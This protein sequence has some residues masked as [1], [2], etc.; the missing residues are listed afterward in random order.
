MQ[1]FVKTIINAVQSWTKKEIK[2]SVADWN[3][4]DASAVDYVK[5]RTHWVDDVEEVIFERQLIDFAGTIQVIFMDYM[6]NEINSW[7]NVK[8][9]VFWDGVTYDCT[10]IGNGTV[11]QINPDFLDPNLPFYIT[12]EPYQT[13]IRKKSEASESIE[14]GITREN[15]HKLDSKYL[16]LPTNL[17]T[18]DDV[19]DAKQEAI[20][21]ANVAQTT[22]DTAQTTADGK[23]DATNPVGTGKLSFGSDISLTGDHSIAMG[24]N[25][26]EKHRSVIVLGTNNLRDDSNYGTG[27]EYS[28]YDYSL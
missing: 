7:N 28:G 24:T 9:H 5:N 22:A 3:Q 12:F 23:M 19:Q 25:L 20:D 10:V 1:N 26:Q 27:G 14:F 6:D 8:V 2:N 18:T 15:I 4:N 11:S 21:V 16:D 17:A 13:I